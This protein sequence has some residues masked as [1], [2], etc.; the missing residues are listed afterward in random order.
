MVSQHRLA[1]PSRA[2]EINVGSSTLLSSAPAASLRASVCDPKR[3]SK[4]LRTVV[5]AYEASASVDQGEQHIERP[6][7]ECDELAID[8]QLAL[9][10]SH[11][12]RCEAIGGGHGDERTTHDKRAKQT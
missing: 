12:E 7:A 5:L 11:L 2:S 6:L 10:G 8:Q 4:S 3:A 1:K 9:G